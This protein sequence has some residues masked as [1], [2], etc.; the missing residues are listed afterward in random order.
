MPR[1]GARRSLSYTEDVGPADDE[2]IVVDLGEERKKR[3]RADTFEMDDDGE[4]QEVKFKAKKAAQSAD[5]D[6]FYRNLAEDFEEETLDLWGEDIVEQVEDAIAERQ[7]WRDRFE[8]GLEQ[9]GLVESDIDDGPFP[10]ASNAVHPLLIEARTQFW[11]RAMAELWPPEGPC[12]AKVE[13]DQSDIQ[14]QRAERVKEYSNFQMMI[15]DEACV[16]EFS[17][18][19]WDTPFYGSTFFKTYRDPV[20]D[21]NVSVYVPADDLIVPAEAKSLR[22]APF[23]C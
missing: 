8:M 1:V 6:D 7:P 2:D 14:I 10:G 23:F 4:A 16:E 5:T 15:E 13:G 9:M 12:K 11:A 22:T 17:S 18:L 19:L 21:H 20:L 3:G